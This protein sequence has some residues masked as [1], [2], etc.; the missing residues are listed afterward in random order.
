MFSQKDQQKFFH[1]KLKI[2]TLSA[3]QT[4]AVVRIQKP[5]RALQGQFTCGQEDTKHTHTALKL[6]STRMSS[7]VSLGKS[8]SSESASSSDKEPTISSAK[9]EVSEV[10][11]RKSR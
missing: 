10:G 7:S 9:P 5:C 6:T 11:C 1:F 2:E 3:I 8:S 4:M